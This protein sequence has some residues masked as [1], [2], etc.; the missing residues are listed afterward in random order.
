MK[1]YLVSVF[2]TTKTYQIKKLIEFVKA[3]SAW[4]AGVILE[5]KA[6]SKKN[7]LRINFTDVNAFNKRV[8]LWLF[9][10]TNGYLEGFAGKRRPIKDIDKDYEKY[11]LKFGKEHGIN[12]LDLNDFKNL[13]IQDI[14][15]KVCK[16]EQYEKIQNNRQGNNRNNQGSKGR[17]SAKSRAPRKDA[18]KKPVKRRKRNKKI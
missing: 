15:Y 7:F 8:V 3:K 4:D 2:Y 16:N 5:A 11:I 10:M 17:K 13:T 12:D 6:K 14:L 1:E 18:G 9:R